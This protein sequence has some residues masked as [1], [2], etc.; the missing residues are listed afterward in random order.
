MCRRR[1][2]FA[3]LLALS[4]LLSSAAA[5]AAPGFDTFISHPGES[6]D[7]PGN[8]LPAFKLAVERG[9]GFECDLRLSRDGRVFTL[10]DATFTHSTDGKCT[11]RCDELCWDEIRRLNVSA[12]GGWKDT[13]FNGMRPALLEEVLDLARDGRWIYLEV[14]DGLEIVPHIARA[15][16][17][18]KRANSGNVLFICFFPNVCREL[19]RQLPAYRVYLLSG[20]R[21]RAGD[22]SLVPIPAEEMVRSAKACGADGIDMCFDI[23]AHTA[24]Y[25]KTVRDADLGF[26]VWTVDDPGV[27]LLA[28][29]RGVQT[30]TTNCA[31]RQ[32]DAI[33][34]SG[35][36][37][38]DPEET[39]RNPPSS[40]KTGVWWHWMGRCVTKEGIVADLD[41][42]VAAGIGS[43]TIFGLADACVP[44]A[45]G[46]A[47]SPFPQLAAF[48][49]EWWRLV[50]F[51]CDEAEKRG[52]ELGVHNCPG[53]TSTGGPWIPPRLAMRELVFNVTNAAEQI[54]LKANARFPI[55]DPATGRVA[56]PDVPARRTD[57]VDIATV[58]GVRIA[59]IP[60]G[61]FVQPAQDEAWGLE[62]DKMSEEAVSF[63]LDHVI[64]DMKRHLGRHVGKTMRFVLLDSYEAGVP[65]WTPRMR[66]EFAARRGYDPLPFLPILGGYHVSAAPDAAAEKKF[67]DDFDRTRKDLYRDV[68][69][70]TMRR[71]LAEAGLE[72]A[73]E[74]YEGPFDSRECAAHVDRV[75]TEFWYDPS[76]AASAPPPRRLGWERWIGPGGRRHNVIEAEAFT[77]QPG[78]C[79]WTETPH[80]LKICGDRQFV[81]GI[82]RFVLHTCPLQ[83]WGGRA[84]PGMTM[85]RWGTHFGRTQTWARQCEA[86][87]SYLNRCQ[88][89]L[90]WGE[91]SDGKL[92][93]K[94]R[95]P[96]AASVSSLLRIGAPGCVAFVAN[97]SDE[98]ADVEAELPVSGKAPEWFDPVS[99]RITALASADGEVPLHLPPR[100][101]GFLVFRRAAGSVAVSPDADLVQRPPKDAGFV[102]EVP[103]Q[104]T[105]RSPVDP[106]FTAKLDRLSDWTASGDVRIRHFSGTAV[107]RA[108]F[109]CPSAELRARTLSLGDCNGQLAQVRLNGAEL[110]VAWCAPWEVRIPSGLLKERGNLI[111]IEFTNVWTNR[112]IGDESHPRDCDFEAAPLGGGERLMRFPQWFA[113]WANGEV[114]RPSGRSCFSTWNY[115]SPG[116]GLV[117]SGL[118]GPVALLL[119]NTDGGRNRE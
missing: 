106:A 16:A 70:A 96:S 30:V 108:D 67:I 97:L 37:T 51:A 99:G 41:W 103:W 80:L 65:T 118:V 38:P 107:Y 105:F 25:V 76:A 95:S 116:S 101:S 62:C 73:C 102:I 75:M 89:L 21:R 6:I 117:S 88:A 119:Y 92:V 94:G 44:W 84:M 17:A 34:G 63:H 52:I 12:W 28:F 39:F 56:V 66:E 90:Q 104:V 10:H 109:D 58:D 111:E 64:G 71:K 1:I 15:L 36:L 69:F 77:G 24:E 14:K 112:L 8:T 7:A 3:C 18:Q 33:F 59:H 78:N 45:A 72:F 50:R 113:A 87:I 79:Q 19:K 61:S 22:G 31:K 114:G 53:Y 27:S 91:P 23:K 60:M 9:F 20:A 55:V 93:V 82:N 40:A 83:P 13:E 100:A 4:A 57:V 48:T 43:A 47:D 32:M 46:I 54:S 42:F 11:N 81:R 35:T 5:A 49:P 68:L 26:H 98:P 110:G 115:F 2:A 85:G 29:R 74:P 86:W